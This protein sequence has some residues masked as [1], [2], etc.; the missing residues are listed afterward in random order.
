MLLVYFCICGYAHVWV[1]LDCS[2]AVDN[3]GSCYAQVCL[4][5]LFCFGLSSCQPVF[6]LLEVLAHDFCEPLYC[7]KLVGISLVLPRCIYFTLPLFPLLM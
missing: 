2:A 3:R 6:A 7:A 5:L 1:E 4:L